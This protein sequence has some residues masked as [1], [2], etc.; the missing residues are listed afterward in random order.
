M[1]CDTDS[2]AYPCDEGR[3]DSCGLYPGPEG[4]LWAVDS[5]DREGYL[6]EACAMTPRWSY[7]PMDEYALPGGTVDWLAEWLAGD[8][9]AGG[10]R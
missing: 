9:Y 7:D 4:L 10:A 8:P 5:R 1:D 6:C 2:W 3:C